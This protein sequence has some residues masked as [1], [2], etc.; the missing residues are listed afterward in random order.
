[1]VMLFFLIIHFHTNH[2]VLIHTKVPKIV[3][4]SHYIRLVNI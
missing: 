4:F 2:I 1:M 3:K